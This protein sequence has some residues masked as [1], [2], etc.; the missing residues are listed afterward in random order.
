MGFAAYVT[1]EAI[2]LASQFIGY[3]MGFGT[4]NLMDPHSDTQASV[5]VSLNGWIAMMV[6]FAADMHHEVLRLF[7]LSFQI[8]KTLHENLLTNPQLIQYII[9]LGTKLFAIS[10]QVAAPFTFLVLACNVAIGVLS[11][12]L[13]QMNVL[14]F[15]FPITISVGIIA[16]YLLTPDLMNVMDSIL[17]NMTSEMMTVLRTL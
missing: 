10:V 3:Q 6:F 4:S 7:V 11:R 13:P 2:A 15:S 5:L 17:G 16:L 14:L 8:T 12:M 9:S 1:F